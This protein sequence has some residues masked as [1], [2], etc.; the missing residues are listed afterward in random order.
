MQNVYE[1]LFIVSSKKFWIFLWLLCHQNKVNS[2]HYT[3]LVL[4]IVP[5]SYVI[6]K[7]MNAMVYIV[8][9][10]QYFTNDKWY[11]ARK[12]IKWEK[13]NQ[14]ACGEIF[15]IYSAWHN[16][17]RWFST[18]FFPT[19]HSFKKKMKL[20]AFS[21]SSLKLLYRWKNIDKKSQILYMNLCLHMWIFWWFILS[22]LD[23]NFFLS[24]LY[25]P[26]VR[27]FSIN[28]LIFFSS[29]SWWFAKEEIC[30]SINTVIK[31]NIP[32]SCRNRKTLGW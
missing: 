9:A 23:I 25:F 24:Y 20:T 13:K 8:C 22:T 16:A 7:S 10:L 3:T 14:Q 27:L 12:R 2:L 18:D 15:Y 26:F 19:S 1:S 21:E 29:S 32:S 28:F 17:H 6:I 31:L 4:Q 5:S 30:T 11:I